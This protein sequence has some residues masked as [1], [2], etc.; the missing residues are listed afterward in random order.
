MVFAKNL[1]SESFEA[2]V[3]KRVNIAGR[4]W[5]SS[6]R[7]SCLLRDSPQLTP[8]NSSGEEFRKLS[9]N[10]KGGFLFVLII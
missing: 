5:L 4:D 2:H 6:E 1:N 7:T 10:D 8:E 9:L 3:Q